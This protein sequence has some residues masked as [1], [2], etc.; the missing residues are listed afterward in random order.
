VLAITLNPGFVCILAALVA[1]AAPRVVRPALI[2]AAAALALW[3]MLDRE[4]GAAQAAR[5][6][7]LP[8]VLLQLDALNRIFGIAM[9]I[10]LIVIGVATGARRN[11]AED[12]AILTLAG[13]AVSALFCRRSD[14]LRRRGVA[15]RNCR[16]LDR[17]C[18]A[19]AQLLAQ[20]RPHADLGRA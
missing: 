9:L 12:A 7:G 6:M 1:L 15:L 4:F 14:Q 10:A 19:F 11:R 13:G 16:R 17:V 20:R 3:L 5:Q 2:V 18:V 8:V